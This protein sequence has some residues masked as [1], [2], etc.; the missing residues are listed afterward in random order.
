[1][2]LRE[3]LRKSPNYRLAVSAFL[4]VS[5]RYSRIFTWLAIER[6]ADRFEG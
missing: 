2:V 4:V 6:L 1:M 5:E 3:N